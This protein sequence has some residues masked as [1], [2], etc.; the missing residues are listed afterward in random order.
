MTPVKQTKL[1]SVDGIHNGNCYTACLSSLLDL[2]LWMVPPFEDMFGRGDGEWKR[3]TNEWLDRM[4]QL[5]L[6]RTEG[7][8]VDALPEFYIANGWSPRGVYHSVIYR[9]GEMMS[10]PHPSDSGIVSI[11]WCYH[12]E[13]LV[14]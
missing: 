14:K 4:F 1:Y 10:D 2:P 6:V 9:R 13:T 5:R 3:R 11:E 8:S 7:H 12:L